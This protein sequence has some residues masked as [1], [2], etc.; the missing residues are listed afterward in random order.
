M[1]VALVSLAL[2]TCATTVHAGSVDVK[3]VAADQ[4]TDAGQGRELALVQT[5]LAAHLKRLGATML[6]DRRSLAI[7]VLD[8]DLA[9]AV[10]PSRSNFQDLR[11]LRG[12]ADWPQVTLRFALSEGGEVIRRGDERLI[13]MNYLFGARAARYSSAEAYPY[14]KRMLSAWF[15]QR[16][17]DP[18]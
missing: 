8:I 15:A 1:R 4:Y 9:G 13:D 2:A 10:E 3:F 6:A 7:E 11:I 14:E 16:I 17:A 5:E 12:R 18:R